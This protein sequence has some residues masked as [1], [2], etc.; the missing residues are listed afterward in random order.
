MCHSPSE[1]EAERHGLGG[2]LN[3]ILPMAVG[4]PG[5][6]A[7]TSHA[8]QVNSDSATLLM[9]MNHRAAAVHN[10]RR[11]GASSG[12]PRVE[13]R[14]D[15]RAQGEYNVLYSPC[16]SRDATHIA[17]FLKTL[18]GHASLQWWWGGMPC[19]CCK[20]SATAVLLLTNLSAP[21]VQQLTQGDTRTPRNR[22]I[23]RMGT[24]HIYTCSTQALRPH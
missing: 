17:D 1:A 11:C 7:L 19:W 2:N 20:S 14:E 16:A 24:P 13:V 4:G 23:G 21:D 12:A 8:S 10:W 6:D 15:L 5:P 18:V 3:C 9:D 22:R